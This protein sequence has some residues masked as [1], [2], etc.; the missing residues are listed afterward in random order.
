MASFSSRDRHLDASSGREVVFCYQCRHEWYRDQHA[1][2]AC[3]LCDNQAVEIVDPSNDPRDLPENSP[4]TAFSSAFSRRRRPDVD[5]DHEDDDI[6]DHFRPGSFPGTFGR[7]R[8]DRGAP[9][10]PDGGDVILRR[11]ADLLMNDLGG[12]RPPRAQPDP[13]FPFRTGG[14]RDEDHDHFGMFPPSGPRPSGSP[15]TYR[16]TT[17]RSGPVTGTATFTFVSSSNVPEGAA[18]PGFPPGFP[19]LFSQIMSNATPPPE[20]DGRPAGSPGPRP[21][22]PDGLNFASGLHEILAS[23]LNPQAAVHGD[24]VYTQEA[25]D[26]IITSLMEANPSSNA[27]P[28]ASQTAIDRLE[29]K[30][31]DDAML[32]PEGKAECTICIDELKKGDEVTSL[33]CTHWFHGECVI[34]WL[35]EHNTC[36]ICRAP[37]EGGQSS[38]SGSGGTQQPSASQ[39]STSQPQ[40]PRQPEYRRPLFTSRPERPSRNPQENAERLAALRN[41]GNSLS[42]SATHSPVRR[43]SLSPSSTRDQAPTPIRRVRSPSPSRDRPVGDSQYDGGDGPGEGSRTQ[44]RDNRNRSSQG[45]QSGRDNHGGAFNWIREHLTRSYN[46][47]SDR[48]RD[49]RR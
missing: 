5:S 6:G 47:Q 12:A 24:A 36:P 7:Q 32:G 14:N 17:F 25:L 1:D 21:M 16:H 29:K 49:R 10:G 34:L 38:S 15:A 39:S 4:S 40:A 18:P 26:R 28:P 23:L 9:G 33:P 27:A 46:S 11:F 3:P 48:D 30:K 37:I 43:N 22:P 13:F 8:P 42:G 20:R 45:G 31:I 41:L 19:T 2:L 44:A 35:K